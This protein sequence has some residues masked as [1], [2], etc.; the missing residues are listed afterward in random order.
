M[1]QFIVSLHTPYF[2]FSAVVVGIIIS[3]TANYATR[4]LDK[5]FS[6]GTSW[7]RTLSQK[8]HDKRAAVADH[9]SRWID[10]SENGAAMALIESHSLNI[11]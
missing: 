11:V 6:S 3:V 8:N 4:F 9:I 5:S 1:D 10:A 2:W 7:V